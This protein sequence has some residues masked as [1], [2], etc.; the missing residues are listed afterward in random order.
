MADITITA[1]DVLVADSVRVAAVEAGVA[2]TAGQ[3]LVYDPTDDDYILASNSTLALSGNAGAASI[4]MAVGAAGA[5]QRVAVVGGGNTITV[6]S[7]LSKGRVYV[8]SANGLIS[9]ESD[10]TTGD[11]VTIIGYA[12]SATE[13]YFNPQST[14]LEIP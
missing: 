3:V 9:P 7:V 12:L 13:L 6:G 11:F 14:G 5:G 10:A 4:V 8:L 1:S 2:V